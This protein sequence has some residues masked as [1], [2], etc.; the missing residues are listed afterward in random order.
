MATQPQWARR[1]RRHRRRHR[2][3]GSGVAGAFA[4]T[5]TPVTPTP[6]GRPRPR[7]A[8]ARSGRLTEIQMAPC[9]G[10]PGSRSRATRAISRPRSGGATS[11]P[12]QGR[13]CPMNVGGPS[14]AL[15]LL[16]LF[17]GGPPTPSPPSACPRQ[18]RP[19]RPCCPNG[20]ASTTPRASTPI[21]VR[22][23]VDGARLAGR[24]SCVRARSTPG[25]SRW[26]GGLRGRAG[27]SPPPLGA[28]ALMARPL[29]RRA[30][31]SWGA[32]GDSASGEGG[33]RT[34]D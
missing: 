13:G 29:R 20:L 9:R 6:I 26:G 22:V 23:G 24:G 1:R 19:V 12:L 34:I 17:S 8:G 18:V 3:P 28:G 15:P 21:G 25:Q 11:G 10:T 30:G 31:T 14:P 33:V 2:H 32:E 4:T 5:R 27:A 16:R 7:W